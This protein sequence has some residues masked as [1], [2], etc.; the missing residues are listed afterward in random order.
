MATVALL[1]FVPV[2]QAAEFLINGK[3]VGTLV[4][5]IVGKEE[6]LATLY[7]PKLNVE[8]H[9]SGGFVIN[10]GLVLSST[11][12]D[13]V[14]TY[15]KCKVFTF[16]TKEELPCEIIP[17]EK[18]TVKAL[19]LP[20]QHG[21]KF[22]LLVEPQS[23]IFTT[24]TFKSGTGC[25]LPLKNSVTGEY[26]GQLV[27]NNVVEPLVTTSEATQKLIGGKLLYGVNEVFINGSATGFLTG[28]H[29]GLTLGMK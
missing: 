5:T 14:V 24:I 23:G 4:A 22:Y 17:E 2:T 20:L 6:G 8:K 18:I 15:S 9:C 29:K 1:S 26:S 12:G 21:E 10:E 13:A 11:D 7:I 19:I 25:T 3:P 16:D 28:V 27:T